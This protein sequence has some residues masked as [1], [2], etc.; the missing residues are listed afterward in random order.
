MTKAGRGRA[1]RIIGES[2][3]AATLALTA[4]V[5]PATAEPEAPLQDPT[6]PPEQNSSVVMPALGESET[7]ATVVRWH[8]E[9][10]DPVAAGETLAEVESSKVNAEIPAPADGVLQE[11]AVGE[12]QT[13]APGATLGVVGPQ[14][15]TPAD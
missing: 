8:K 6:Q 5:A 4:G 14:E 13:A 10:G 3:L 9:V 1:P 12:G 2:C 11:I 15:I 7:E